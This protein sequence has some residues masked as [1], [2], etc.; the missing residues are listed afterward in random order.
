MSER[1]SYNPG[2]FCWVDVAVPNT[3][4]GAEFY[5]RLLGAEWEAGAERFGGYGMF[6]QN[7]KTV[8][9]MGPTMSDDQPPAWTSYVSVEDADATAAKIKEAG[10]TVAMGPMEIEAAGKMAVCQD[11]QGAYFGLWEPGETYGAQLVNVVGTW[12]W[13]HLTTTSLDEAE[14]FYSQVFGWR[15]AG[16]PPEGQPEGEGN[17]YFM[18]HSAGQRWEEGI[19]G[20]SEMGGDQPDMPPNWSVYLAVEDA[21]SAVETTKEAGGEVIVPVTPV[22]VG[23]LAVL[24]DPQGAVFGIIEPDYPEPR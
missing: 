16:P 11:P 12:T 23:R 6:T 22:P 15:I 8:F 13:N 20:A 1:E 2:E 18:W 14:K 24:I 5:K 3:Q 21:D 7:G 4:A 19:G 17:Q 9:G 10:G